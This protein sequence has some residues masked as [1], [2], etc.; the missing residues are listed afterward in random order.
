MICHGTSMS[1]VFSSCTA[2]TSLVIPENVIIQGSY[3]F[4]SWTAKQTIYVCASEAF[5]LANWHASWKTG[6]ATV[7]YDYVVPEADAPEAN[8]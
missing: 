1:Y 5:V 7:V 4:G 8:A 6:S 3:N 2:L